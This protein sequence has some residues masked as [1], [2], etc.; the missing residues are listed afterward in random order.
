MSEDCELARRAA[1]GDKEAFGEL[2]RRHQNAIFRIAYRLLG[3]RAAAEDATQESFLRAWKALPFYDPARPFAPWLKRITVNLCLNLLKRQPPLPFTA[4]KHGSNSP[5][6]EEEVIQREQAHKVH[7]A[8]LSLPPRYRV[9]I[10]LRHFQGLTY[11]EMA[12]ALH[13]PLSDVKSNLF[14][15]RR[16]LLEKLQTLPENRDEGTS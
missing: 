6:P 11:A 5:A 7:A 3:E 1:Q 14:R 8:I 2:V 9:V 12:R 15:A 13:W 16:L 10:E 4:W